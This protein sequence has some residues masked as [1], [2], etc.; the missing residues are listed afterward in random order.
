MMCWSSLRPSQCEWTVANVE[1]VETYFGDYWRNGSTLF[2]DRGLDFLVAQSWT[3]D[4]FQSL[5]VDARNGLADAFGHLTV[6]G[7]DYPT[8]SIPNDL[9]LRTWRFSPNVAA[10]LVLVVARDPMMR[11][12]GF[13]ICALRPVRLSQR[14]WRRL[15]LR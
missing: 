4:E 6:C 13:L 11:V 2:L 10:M 5:G 8:L 3:S 12:I 15:L 14:I 7:G 1:R 9:G